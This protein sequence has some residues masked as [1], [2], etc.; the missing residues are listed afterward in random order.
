[1]KFSE[2]NLSYEFVNNLESL[3]FVEL[4][5]L[6]EL[7]VNDILNKKDVIVHSPTGSGKTLAFAIGIVESLHVSKKKDIQA[8]IIT[9]TRELAKQVANTIKDTCR[10]IHNVKVL[11]LSGGV[12]KKA[13]INSLKHGADIVVATPGRLSDLLKDNHIDIS[14][15][16]T[17][18]LDEADKMLQMGFSDEIDYII[19]CKSKESQNMFFS[20][21]YP[22]E[23]ESLASFINTPIYLKNT[24][25][26]PDIKEYF[27]KSE[28]RLN[29]LEE[30]LL[31]VKPIS[32]V[33]FVNQK[34]KAD[35]ISDYLNMLGYFSESIHS[36]LEQ[37]DRDEILIL[38]ANKSINVLV[39]SDVLARGIDVDDV[40]CVINYEVP[41]KSEVYK[42]RIG[43]GSRAQ[44]SS[45]SYTIVTDEDKN[46]IEDL[47]DYLQRDIVY[48][49][50]TC[51]DFTIK[52]PH[53][54]TFKLFA[55]AK[56]KIRKGDIV[57]ALCKVVEFSDIGKIDIL[58]FDSYVAIKK[59]AY[60]D[61]YIYLQNNKVKNKDIVFCKI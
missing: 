36:D 49:N 47:Q 2:L 45:S 18:V 38:F 56:D 22:E 1:V 10:H 53:Y 17:F 54:K 50:I 40:D 4:S 44:K 16:K 61:V 6:Q 28:N 31:H 19:T 35:E 58:R 8:L 29:T 30:I 60:E 43:R 46:A 34:A 26:I 15:I 51:N 24:Q 55:G 41:F 59:E 37:I 32:T 57:G 48:S 52:E 33:I 3:G 12:P 25:S 23:I 14:N 42:H 39:A 11:T 21:T 20:A 5:D 27:I 13:H 7:A 9:P